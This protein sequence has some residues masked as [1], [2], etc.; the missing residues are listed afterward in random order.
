M[1]KLEKIEFIK[2]PNVRIIGREVAHS[3]A[4]N[5]ENP[6]PS[7]WSQMFNDGT[8]DMLKKLP[9]AILDC[10][11]GWMG[12]T[13]GQTFKYIAGV[14]CESNTPVP[15]GMQYRDLLACDVAKGYIYGNL[16]NGEVYFN[17]YNLTVDG[18]IVNNLK[19]DDSYGWSAEVYPDDLN[20]DESEG[21]ICYFQ[22]YKKCV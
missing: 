10:T 21:I 13:E 8:V 19:P 17:A 2:I 12:D 11:I 22:P 16:Q 14:I 1:A 9:L 6:I 18:I 5:E 4:E 20:F 15:E 7:L 3:M